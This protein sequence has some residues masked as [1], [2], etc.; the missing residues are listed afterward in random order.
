MP[1]KKQKGQKMAIQDFLLTDQFGATGGGSWADEVEDE[2]NITSDSQLQA[3][4][5]PGIGSDRPAW[6]SGDRGGR[7]DRYGPRPIPD[8]PP[9]KAHVSGLPSDMMD[10]EL[11]DAITDAFNE[12]QIEDIS[13]ITTKAEIKFAFI[14]FV[15]PRIS[16]R[17]LAMPLCPSS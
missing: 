11:K 6:G 17:L 15:T 3:F 8:A 16:R 5:K 7:D 13:I 4:R 14:T 1:P 10:D 9:Y 2:I 12:C